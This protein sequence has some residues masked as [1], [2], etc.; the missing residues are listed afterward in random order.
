MRLALE[1]ANKEDLKFIQDNEPSFNAL[2]DSV[3]V[4]LMNPENAA[5]ALG[6]IDQE[7]FGAKYQ[8]IW[9]E[10]YSLCRIRSLSIE[11]EK[12]LESHSL[13]I[14]NISE[15]QSFIKLILRNIVEQEDSKFNII[16]YYDVLCEISNN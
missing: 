16:G 4:D 8:S 9:D 6:Y 2:L 11:N 14:R 7:K 1:N 3:L 5:I 12:L 10:L 13:L 15:K